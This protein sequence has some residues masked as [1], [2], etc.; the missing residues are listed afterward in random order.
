MEHRQNCN[1]SQLC[2]GSTKSLFNSIQ[3][4]YQINLSVRDSS[5]SGEAMQETNFTNRTLNLLFTLCESLAQPKC[6][7][8][9]T[10]KKQRRELISFKTQD[11]TRRPRCDGTERLHNS[12]E[13]SLVELFRKPTPS[14]TIARK[15]HSHPP[16]LMNFT[17]IN[18]ER[19]EPAQNFTAT[20]RFFDPQ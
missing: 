16:C 7:S 6:S 2:I 18:L 15:L 4:K 14:S 20:P 8:F 3:R 13:A 12:R 10:S 17:F 11:S 1:K 9:D 19:F 5:R